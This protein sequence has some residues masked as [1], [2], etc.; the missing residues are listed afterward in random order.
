MRSQPSDR[1]AIT[2]RGFGCSC[3]LAQILKDSPMT[4]RD[5]FVRKGKR[6]MRFFTAF[7]SLSIIVGVLV[8]THAEHEVIRM[9]SAILAVGLPCMFAFVAQNRLKCPHCGR[10]LG[11]MLAND[12]GKRREHRFRYCPTCGFDLETELRVSD[13]PSEDRPRRKK[14][15]APW[16]C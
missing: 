12:E 7:L 10:V 13:Y 15:Q 9:L 2:N 5:L 16:G 6:L 1:T 3:N 11:E 8:G 4:Y 14:R